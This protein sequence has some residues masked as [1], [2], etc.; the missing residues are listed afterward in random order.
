MVHR[1]GTEGQQERSVF[2]LDSVAEA[3][4]LKQGGWHVRVRV[5][6]ETRVDS[7]DMGMEIAFS[8]LLPIEGPWEFESQMA[9]Q[10][11]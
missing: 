5:K 9:G 3:R 4:T 8:Q 11:I 1:E 6:R 7:K 10:F 2:P